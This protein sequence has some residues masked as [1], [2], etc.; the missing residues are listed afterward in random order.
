MRSFDQPRSELRGFTL[1][2]VVV[3]LLIGA[4]AVIVT[5]VNFSQERLTE[6][7]LDNVPALIDIVHQATQ[8]YYNDTCA[9]AAVSDPSLSN[10]TPPT[11]AQLVSQGYLVAPVIDE[12]VST[13]VIEVR[14]PPV[15]PSDP[16]A[17]LA[18]VSFAY[19]VN[20]TSSQSARQLF[21]SS[22]N[23][24]LNGSQVTYE[25]ANN[26]LNRNQFSES[27]ALRRSYSRPDLADARAK[28]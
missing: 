21:E 8:G 15:N 18:Q 9:I 13:V 3:A 14:F 2:E 17:R 5:V 6:A 19:T 11:L 1:I 27:F 7:Q 23:T 25:F 20:L 4:I 26:E 28:C 24:S 10:Y 22:T 16:M 12:V